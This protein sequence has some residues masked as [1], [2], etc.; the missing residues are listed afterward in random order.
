MS[1]KY[2]GTTYTASGV[3]SY[4]QLTDKPTINGK[5]LTGDLDLESIEEVSSLPV[6]INISQLKL[7]KYN[8]TL[9]WFNG[10]QWLNVFTE[11]V[12]TTNAVTQN[13]TNPISSG[14]VYNAIGSRGSEIQPIYA[15]DGQLTTGSTYAGGTAVTLNGT[16]KGASTAEFYAPT[17]PG[18]SGQVLTSNGSGAPIWKAPAA[19]GG[20]SM[21]IGTIIAFAGAVA[22]AGW[23][24][25]DGQTYYAKSAET[26][27]DTIYTAL[28]NVI[29]TTYG[30]SGTANT[31]KVPDFRGRFLEGASATSGHELGKS[32]AS[33]LPT[34][35]LTFTGNTMTGYIDMGGGDSGDWYGDYSKGAKSGVFSWS[36]SGSS[37]K[38]TGLGSVSPNRPIAR[39]NF[40]GTPSGSVT[41]NSKTNTIYGQ[42]T[43]VQPPSV[44]VNY[45]I[46]Y[47]E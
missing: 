11:S 24:L 3:S 13:D 42:S 16:S 45:I 47:L 4:N 9:Y 38:Y 25:C 6:G 43:V 5:P 28:F 26:G 44:C 21:P 37:Y 19:S 29:G 14:G 34:P 40:S 2:K 8:G 17:T 30:T 36:N 15:V 10:T 41:L 46:R 12:S 20:G 32:V 18:T 1:L 27:N 35:A 22:P 31:F 39:L 23:L 7:Y 33:A